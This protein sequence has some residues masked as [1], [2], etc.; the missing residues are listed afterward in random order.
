AEAR[1]GG[2]VE[3]RDIGTVVFPDAELKAFLTA[4]P[5][6]RADRRHR[7]IGG[8]SLETVATE[9]ARRDTLDSQ[10]EESPLAIAPDA[11]RIDTSEQTVDGV[12]E[13]LL[14]RLP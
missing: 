6:V 1:G 9:L 11:V 13:L 7:E 8:Q 12:V 4:R 2:V 14:A 10:R 5:D 3:G